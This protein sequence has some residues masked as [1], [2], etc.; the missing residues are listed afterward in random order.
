MI[1]FVETV[2]SLSLR[3]SARVEIAQTA[4]TVATVMSGTFVIIKMER[5]FIGR[6]HQGSPE[7]V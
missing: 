1:D 3:K 6:K 4:T 7:S 5:Q 2:N